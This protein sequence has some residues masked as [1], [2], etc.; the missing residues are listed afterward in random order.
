MSEE[1]LESDNVAKLRRIKKR[2]EKKGKDSEK[3]DILAQQQLDLNA[4]L[5][6]KKFSQLVALAVQQVVAAHFSSGTNNSVDLRRA[7]I[8]L[9]N[10]SSSVSTSD[11]SASPPPSFTPPLLVRSH[12]SEILRRSGEL[13]IPV[14]PTN[15]DAL[16]RAAVKN[17]SPRQSVDFKETSTNSSVGA[18]S[19]PS[20]SN[21]SPRD[22]TTVM[23]KLKNIFT[24]SPRREALS[25]S[26]AK[27]FAKDLNQTGI[28]AHFSGE[29]K[30]CRTLGKGGMGEV[31]S[32]SYRNLLVAVK[33]YYPLVDEERDKVVAKI[34]AIGNLPEH[35]H[36]I[37]F[38]AYRFEMSPPPDNVQQLVLVM[39]LMS[40][41]LSSIVKQRRKRYYGAKHK[42]V[43]FPERLEIAPFSCSEVAHIMFQILKGV[44][45]LHRH[46]IIHRDLKGENILAI[47]NDCE[48]EAPLS[49]STS[50][51]GLS[52]ST[53]S[54]STPTVVNNDDDEDVAVS[55]ITA[56]EED[57][58]EASSGESDRLPPPKNVLHTTIDIC[59]GQEVTII[60]PNVGLSYLFKIGDFDD[61]RI[62]N[63][64]LS[65]SANSNFL[66]RKSSLANSGQKP[67]QK[68]DQKS[69]QK[70]MSKN[71]GTPNF[72]A[73]E[74][75]NRKIIDYTTAVD[76]WSLGMILYFLLTLEIPYMNEDGDIS[77]SVLRA[78]EECRL[79]VLPQGYIFTDEWKVILQVYNSCVQI[80]PEKRMSASDLIQLITKIL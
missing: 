30:S 68:P 72:R 15:S 18:S 28:C 21:V 26:G 22:N 37:P 34:V 66:R 75:V 36:I 60:A 51:N 79:P 6:S 25:P 29:W 52:R 4:F 48:T 56:N 58:E 50:H 42:R 73:P 19:T 77:F 12:S 16:R 1:P 39:G 67:D 65:S 53:S 46:N 44:E 11:L 76:I 47:E 24:T 17:S 23:S 38:F 3:L 45:H 78:L 69:D 49:R 40:T 64:Q 7:S 31:K 57:D 43:S 61:A 9:S 63:A 70:R 74:M 13:A 71:V 33:R 62:G 10:T 59:T 2:K 41:S 8:S 5:A 32:A 35:P 55:A 54:R 27:I 80:D 20:S 14:S